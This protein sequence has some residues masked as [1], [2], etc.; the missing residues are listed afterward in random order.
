MSTTKTPMEQQYDEIKSRHEDKILL[1]RLGDFYEIFNDDAQIAAN[2]LNITVTKRHNRVMCGFPYHALDQYAYKL[3]EAGHKVAI[4]EQVED[5]S[6]AKGLV[7]RDITSVLTKGTWGEN[8]LLDHSVN[9]FLAILFFDRGES[10]LVFA[11]VSTGDIIIR[12][13][14]DEHSISFITDEMNR[15]LPVETICNK[16]LLDH[17]PID[18]E[19]KIY[20]NTLRVMDD[21]YFQPNQLYRD[22]QERY[23][24]YF[25][26]I[27][28]AKQSALMGLF[29]YL[30]ENHLSND[31]TKHFKL[32]FEY[33]S[34]DVLFMNEDTL[35]H[36]ELI[37]N[38]QDFSTKNTLF[39]VLNKNKTMPASR[40]LRRLL[41]APSARNSEVQQQLERTDY[42]YSLNNTA[43]QGLGELLKGMSDLER[44][45]ARLATGKI[46]P[47]E[48]L[49]FADSI[50]RAERLKDFLLSALPFQHYI[51]GLKSFDNIT[52]RIAQEIN[53]ECSN[54]ID[55]SVIR[56][57]VNSELDE[58][59][60]IL[61]ESKEYLIK[62]QAQE[63]M[64][65]GIS[66]LKISYNKI[67]GYYIEISKG[68][69]SKVPDHYVR[70]QSLVNSE[71]FSIPELESFE[72][73]MTQA[74][75]MITS[76]E[77]Q[78][79][80][81]LITDLQV[82]YQDLLPLSEFVTEVDLRL[83]LAYVAKNNRYVKPEL[84]E[85]FD[86][87]IKEGRHPIVETLLKKERFVSNE[88]LIEQKAPVLIVTGPNM[89]GK[90]TY[91]RQNALFAVMAQ[92][93]S[94]IPAKSANLGI[95]DKI[96]TRIGASDDL[97]AGRSTFFVEMQE[98]AFIV[99]NSTP[100]SL[101]I[102]DEL[103]RGTSTKDGLALAWAILEH[104]LINPQKK[105]KLFFST[106]YHELTE[107]GKLNNVKNLC[108]AIEEKNGKVTFLR[109]VVN[110]AASKSYGI[111]VAEMAGLDKTIVQRA[112]QIMNGLEKGDFF[113]SSIKKASEQDLFSPKEASF[114]QIEII[115]EISALSPDDLTPL[116]ALLILSDLVK[117]T[118]NS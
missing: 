24:E 88:T 94:F 57:G 83:A 97:S 3:V 35:K 15:F 1:F 48:I 102:M 25:V 65:T 31:S 87:D 43:T 66:T 84:T 76:L 13:S 26:D 78:I 61:N 86:W 77:L 73:K 9:S 95:V 70:K 6:Q 36:L 67:Y 39:S 16:N 98:A 8:P 104:F 30:N 18:E 93:G 117:R 68:V 107:L 81:Q 40:K 14:H 17:F 69:S 114:S 32:P 11:D 82:Y 111:H 50:Q 42:F 103:G 113:Q 23:E 52:D 64:D 60:S 59:K 89:A 49:A 51:A 75:N 115:N 91:L 80:Q 110:G 22:F 105:C 58:W 71:R 92:I 96:F 47:R 38:A 62:L 4:C 44:L 5:A 116:E 109:K 46:L 28:F 33:P 99:K 12:A 108:M 101:V 55:G 56:F 118:K 29:A 90:S 79:Y 45:I 20:Q 74:E 53:P 7:K 85:K 112:S 34:S 27:S 2:V 54:M 41:V 100:N 106:H 63:R 72:Q 21:S 10:V 37:I 19:L